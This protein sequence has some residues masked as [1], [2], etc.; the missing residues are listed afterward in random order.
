MPSSTI[1]KGTGG[2][3]VAR[4]TFWKFGFVGQP[5]SQPAAATMEGGA[6]RKTHETPT[7]SR[8]CESWDL[9]RIRIGGIYLSGPTVRVIPSNYLRKYF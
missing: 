4:T 5:V 8:K 2:I 7:P 1:R 3:V 9:S 6:E